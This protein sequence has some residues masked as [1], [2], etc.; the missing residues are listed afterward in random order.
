MG[1]QGPLARS[2]EDLVLG[3]DAVRGADAGENVAWR[4]DLPTPRHDRLADFRVAVLPPIE[5]TPVD[6]EILAAQNNLAERLRGIGAR[7]EET[8]PGALADMREHFKLYQRILSVMSSIQLSPDERR[9]QA[10]ETRASGDPFDIAFAEGIEAG[11]ADYIRWFAQRERYRAAYREF[12]DE[13]DILLA[14]V[15]PVVAY[16]HY[17][18]DIPFPERAL[19]VNGRHLTYERGLVH[20]SIATLSG[21]PATAFPA[22][23][24]KDGLPIGLQAIGPYLEDYTPLRFAALV[25]REWGGFEPPPGYRE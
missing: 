10:E 5:W 14:P 9:T 20:P 22:G 1:V 4:L 2:A 21:Q 25:A 6:D 15:F 24:T 12:F 13:W 18:L 16:H 11:A 23:R 3:F 8:Q 17:G 7:V 19:V